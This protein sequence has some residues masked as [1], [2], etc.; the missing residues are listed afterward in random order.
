LHATI[1]EFNLIAKKYSVIIDVNDENFRN[2]DEISTTGPYWSVDA[3]NRFKRLR[4]RR[5]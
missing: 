4:W 2:I 3:V 1:N 5:L